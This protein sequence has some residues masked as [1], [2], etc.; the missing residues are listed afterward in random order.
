MEDI[1]KEVAKDFELM[2]CTVDE[3]CELAKIAVDFGGSS[4]SPMSIGDATDSLVAMMRN[5][6]TSPELLS[7]L[8]QEVRNVD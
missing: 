1:Y 4:I 5:F 6:R 8:E 3:A 7:S 2:G